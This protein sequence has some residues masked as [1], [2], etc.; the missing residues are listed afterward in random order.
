MR[1][2][3]KAKQG[4]EINYYWLRHGG[5]EYIFVEFLRGALYLFARTIVF[6]SKLTILHLLYVLFT[7]KS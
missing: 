6:I 7:K 4:I 3:W 1:C 2:W 5:A